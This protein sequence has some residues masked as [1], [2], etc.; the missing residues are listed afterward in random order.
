MTMYCLEIICDIVIGAIALSTAW[1]LLLVFTCLSFNYELLGGRAGRIGQQ[2]ASKESKRSDAYGQ[3]IE[4][5]KLHM[6]MNR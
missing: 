6:K 5:I 4:L 3:M 2:S 1:Y